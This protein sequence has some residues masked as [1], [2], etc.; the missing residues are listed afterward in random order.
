MCEHTSH[1]ILDTCHC[2]H[3]SSWKHVPAG[4]PQGSVLFLVMVNSLAH[5]DSWRWKYI[6]DLTVAESFSVNQDQSDMPTSDDRVVQHANNHR[7]K[8]SSVRCKEMLVCFQRVLPDIPKIRIGDDHLERVTTY[9]LLGVHVTYDLTWNDERR[10]Q[11]GS[12]TYL[13]YKTAQT[14]WCGC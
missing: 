12:K 2:G 1:V 14:S 13:F 6:D 5:Q 10:H 3:M 7:M 9:K 11:E 4:I 8:L